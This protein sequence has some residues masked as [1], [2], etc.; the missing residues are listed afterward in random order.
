MIAAEA[1]S[2][3]VPEGLPV[4]VDDTLE[5]DEVDEECEFVAVLEDDDVED[6]ERVSLVEGVAVFVL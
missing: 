2:E 4:P 1:V 5:L 6:T 3:D